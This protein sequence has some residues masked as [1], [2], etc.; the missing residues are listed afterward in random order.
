MNR[1]TI[2]IAV[3]AVL[4]LGLGFVV[5]GILTAQ[6]KP[7]PPPKNVVVSTLAVPK[8]AKI[9]PSML[10]VV[11]K[12]AE[13]APPDAL[14]DPAQ[15]AGDVATA[16]IPAGAIVTVAMIGKPPT[17]PPD[18][19]IIPKGMRAMTLQID[20]VKG[21][22]GLLRPGDRVDVVAA[23][24]HGGPQIAT[25]IVVD[26]RV[27]AVGSDTQRVAPQASPGAIA[28][29][30]VPATTVTLALTPSQVDEV[31]SADLNGYVRLVLRPPHEA[32]S[33]QPVESLSYSTPAPS[34]TLPPVQVV[35]GDVV[36]V[37]PAQPVAPNYNIVLPNLPGLVPKPAPT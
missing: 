5:Y 28:G 36:T 7:P 34:A 31:A 26:A 20:P 24:T 11:Q 29:P 2:T 33:A 35:N 19:V 1:K 6:R 17:P 14:S 15:T 9:I 32:S 22:A 23:L 10:S 16:D 3:V 25:T 27:L 30:V 21:V 4:A 37:G 12:P 8:N 18:L 13:E